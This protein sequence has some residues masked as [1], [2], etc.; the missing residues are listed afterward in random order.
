MSEKDEKKKEEEE[1]KNGKTSK[2]QNIL[3]TYRVTMKIVNTKYGIINFKKQTK[4]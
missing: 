4:T 3:K 1:G 2:V